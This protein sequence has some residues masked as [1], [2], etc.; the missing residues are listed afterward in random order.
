[1]PPAAQDFATII[2][3]QRW[4]RAIASLAG[5]STIT[6]AAKHAGCSRRSLYNFRKSPEFQ[7]LLQRARQDSECA[8]RA[9]HREIGEELVEEMRELLHSRKRG[10]DKI[11]AAH[12]VLD[13]YERLNRVLSGPESNADRD[14]AAPPSS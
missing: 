7:A 6:Q 3:E 14:N 10:P 2:R 4:I 5:G 8:L 9:I 1:M 11:R 13:I 12:A